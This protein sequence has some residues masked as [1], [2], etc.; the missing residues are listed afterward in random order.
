ME[1]IWL[2]QLLAIQ[3]RLQGLGTLELVVSYKKEELSKEL[4]NVIQD[5]SSQTSKNH[6]TTSQFIGQ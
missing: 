3:D 2:L 1:E 5:E 4:L 6:L